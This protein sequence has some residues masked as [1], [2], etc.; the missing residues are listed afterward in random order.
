MRDVVIFSGSDLIRFALRAII[1]PVIIHRPDRVS[2]VLKICTSLPEF[3]REILTSVNP[4][5]IFDIDNVPVFN[6]YYILNMIKIKTKKINI[7]FYSKENKLSENYACF[8]G[9]DL[10]HLCKT[11][12]VI[13]IKST[14]YQ[15][16][17]RLV[18]SVNKFPNIFLS[19]K[20]KL[21]ELTGRENQILPLLMFGMTTKKIADLLSISAKTISSHKMNILKKYQVANL[22][23]LYNKWK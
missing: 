12:T 5:V 23:E 18:T 17:Y 2:A 6:Q 7:V 22:V 15:C 9:M 10:V 11:A 16:F 13:E 19:R 3:E 8:K 4:I 21:S 14:I 1:E 20:D